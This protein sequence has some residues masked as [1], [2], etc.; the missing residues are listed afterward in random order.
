[1]TIACANP[2]LRQPVKGVGETARN[3]GYETNLLVLLLDLYYKG[4]MD[5][6]VHSESV[7]SQCDN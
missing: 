6:K 5:P 4:S 2:S 3:W 7:L 1:M